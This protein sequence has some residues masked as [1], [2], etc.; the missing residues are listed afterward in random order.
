MESNCEEVGMMLENPIVLAAFICFLLG[1]VLSGFVRIFRCSAVASIVLPIVYLCS[2]VVTYQQVPPF[3]PVGSTNKI[4]Y[5]ALAAMLAG[6]ALDLLPRTAIY[7]RLLAVIMPLLIVGWIGFPRFAKP[8]IELIATA[9]GLWLGGVALLWRLDTVATDPPERNGGSIVGTAMLM[10]LLLAFAPVALLG[11]SS[12]S[13]ML[14]LAAVAGLAAAALWEIFVPRGAFG[15]SAVFG[16]GGGLLAMID[17]VTLIT[18]EIDLVALALILL[19]PYA[20]EA[21]ARLLLHPNRFR[22]RFR[23]MLV[24]IFTASPL[25]LVIAVLFFRHRESMS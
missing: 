11:G 19:I 24:G 22:G 1:L 9:L 8:E 4:F 20:G 12:T 21:G 7:R 14:C 2:Y 15:A 3:P 16:V 6:L 10:A 18:R 23:Q 17:T 13:L 25:L 5:I